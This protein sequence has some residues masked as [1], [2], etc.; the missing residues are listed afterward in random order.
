[1]NK[2]IWGEEKCYVYSKSDFEKGWF[3]IFPYLR[4]GV[5][6]CIS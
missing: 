5:Y 3:I 6:L 1:M 2:K 4:E